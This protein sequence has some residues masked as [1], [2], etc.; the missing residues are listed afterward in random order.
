[1]GNKVNIFSSNKYWKH[2]VLNL[3]SAGTTS[4]LHPSHLEVAN[5]NAWSDM[6]RL[7]IGL[8]KHWNVIKLITVENVP[9]TF[10]FSLCIILIVER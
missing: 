4:W 5:A 7:F 3:E 2:C 9:N 8:T 1:M 10:W 6:I